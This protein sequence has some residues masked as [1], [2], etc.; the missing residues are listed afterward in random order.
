MTEFSLVA[1]GTS[2]GG[3]KALHEVI[4]GLPEGLNTAVMIV[5]HMSPGFTV[6]LAQR[7]DSISRFR[8]KVAEH[9]DEVQKNH[10]YLAPE[11]HHMRVRS[12]NGKLVI[13]LDQSPAVNGHRP[14]VDVMMQS[15]AMIQAPKVGVIMTGMGNDGANGMKELK[16]SGASTIAESSETCVVYG[17]PKAAIQLGAIDHEVPLHQIVSF[18]V[19]ALNKK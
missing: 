16:K 11:D 4:R 17:M 19:R 18:V 10:A 5:Q 1:I 6:S 12:E 7:L 9:G 15:V 2:T 14:S 13:R 3:P 8:V